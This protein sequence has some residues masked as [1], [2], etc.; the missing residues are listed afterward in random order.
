MEEILRFTN[1][2]A[3]Y[4]KAARFASEKTFLRCTLK[5]KCMLKLCNHNDVNT[6]EFYTHQM[7]VIIKIIQIRKIESKCGRNK[8]KKVWEFYNREM[9]VP[10]LREHIDGTAINGRNLR[11]RFA[12]MA[13]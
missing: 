3:S 6:I 9:L 2:G 12:V 13:K 8:S 5:K 4:L 10:K 1:G 7:I 11:R